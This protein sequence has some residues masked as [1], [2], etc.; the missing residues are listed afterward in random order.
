MST[1]TRGSSRATFP[2][3]RVRIPARFSELALPPETP[4]SASSAV[5]PTVRGTWLLKYGCHA[6]YFMNFSKQTGLCARIGH[7]RIIRPG[8]ARFFRANHIQHARNHTLRSLR[9]TY[10]YDFG[11]LPQIMLMTVPHTVTPLGGG[12]FLISLWSYPGY[13]EVDCRERAVHYHLREDDPADDHVLG[14]V[15]W[16]EAEAGERYFMTYSL[17]DSMQRALDPHRPVASRILKRDEASGETEEVWSGELADYLHDLMI[18]RT[19]RYMVACE[20]GMFLDSDQRIIPSKVLVLDLVAGKQWVLSRFI[21]AAHAQFDP[22]E[23]DVIYFS[24]HNFQFRP[25]NLVKLYANAAYDIRFHGPAS[26]FKYRLTP[27][28]P[29]EIG[30]FT[31]PGFFRLTN[32]HAFQ[33]RGRTIVVAMGSPNYLFVIDAETMKLLKRIEVHHRPGLS[34][35][36][37]KLP[38][39]IGTFSPS[40]DGEKLYVH[41]N[42]SFQVIDVDT[43]EPDMV[44]SSFWNHS[45]SNHMVTSTDV[46]W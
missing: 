35:L 7:A 6:Y 18:D 44:R 27:E 15:Q 40:L 12:R 19:G 2:M 32:M 38:C 39:M 37:R 26:V 10:H 21:V 20:L 28:G 4:R 33:H 31:D 41:T 16:R 8:L 3:R 46:D 9:Q 34:S 45:C 25:T 13:L 36:F 1:T 29:E 22:V 43:G 17:G 24:N 23:P 14:S 5:I 30:E 42:R 11:F